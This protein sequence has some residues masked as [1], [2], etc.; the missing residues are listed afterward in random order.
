[1]TSLRI[2]PRLRI[3]LG[4]AAFLFTAQ[5]MAA[6]PV[7]DAALPAL[8]IDD[9]GEL[10]IVGDEVE[11]TPWSTQ[12]KAGQV[13]IIQYLAATKSASEIFKPL[14]DKLQTSFE[15]G[16]IEVTTVINL[17][18]AMWGTSGF[19]ASEVKK[20]KLEHPESAMVLDKKGTGASEWELGKKGPGLLIV[21]R[22]GIVKFFATE[23]LSPVDVDSVIALIKSLLEP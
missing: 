21:N 13:H 19:V 8:S 14:T 18:A 1:M 20:N 17:K 5:V 15:P 6:A 12:N 10:Q 4:A 16:T 11:Y 7:V 23:A 22:E 2:Y 9:K 3:L